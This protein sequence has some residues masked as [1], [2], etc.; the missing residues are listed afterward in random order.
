MEASAHAP[1]PELQDW[2]GLRLIPGVGSLTFARLLAAFG[3]P[4][5]ALGAPTDQLRALGL[6]A[7][8]A[9]AVHNRAWSADPER[10]LAELAALGG[11]VV[12]WDDADYPPLLKAIYAPP[13]LV[14]VR[15]DLAGCRAGGVAL[16]GSR[17]MSNYGGR[18]A[19]DLARDLA[20]AGVCVIS[21][22]ARG[23]DTVAHQ[24][25]LLA[26]GH[27]VGVLGCGLDV[28]YPPENKDLAEAMA[29]KGAV[30]SEFP[31]GMAPLAGNFPARNR[32]ISGLSRAVVVVEAGL[33]SGALI[34]ARH[35][36]DQGREVFAVPG[37]VGSAQSQGCH[38][39]ISQ[40]ARLLSS[41]HELL[42]PGALPPPPEA[43]GPDAARA[44]AQAE[45]P[46]EAQAL[47]AHLG[48]EPVHVD[49]LARHSG[50]RPQEVTALLI[51]LE[52]AGLVE[53]RPG[54]QYVRC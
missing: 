34:T 27:T 18:V 23:V 3:A 47:L 30:L 29:Q 9:Q 15:G 25:A 21:G 32:V 13:P 38:A 43:A 17:N 33:K 1:R 45:L 16:V 19:A 26:G 22:L 37:Q 42:A 41:A 35:A 36:L 49:L 28:N 44:Q 20:R 50:L 6:R 53:Q 5:P 11:R 31:L 14:F 52:L 4:G 54:K 12:T 7:D 24:A 39:L 2:V 10:Q 48:P 8:V 51:N 40:G 46:A